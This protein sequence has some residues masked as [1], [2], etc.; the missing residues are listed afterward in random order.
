MVDAREYLTYIKLT[1]SRIDLKLKQIQTLEER[2]QNISPHMDSEYVSHTRNND[3]M[4]DTVAVII[5]I[6]KQ[7]DRQTS[8][9]SKNKQE[10]F[11]IFDQMTPKYAEVLM[12][13][14]INRKTLQCISITN[15]ITVRQVQRRLHDA[16]AEFQKILNE[17]NS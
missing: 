10:A 12:E 13:F 5:D 15:Q 2:L 4:G 3:I 9:I 7:I 1:E 11:R 17:S 16:I 14:Y 6:Q 8:E